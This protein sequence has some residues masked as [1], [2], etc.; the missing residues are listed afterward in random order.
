[1]E[2]INI[3]VSG[4]RMLAD[5]EWV[6]Y[7]ESYT[8]RISKAERKALWSGQLSDARKR[9]LVR[10]SQPV[11]AGPGRRDIRTATI[12]GMHFSL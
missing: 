6:D 4:Y 5:G 9:D 2:K 10:V 12:D 8:H 11:A 1:M 7:S 3:S